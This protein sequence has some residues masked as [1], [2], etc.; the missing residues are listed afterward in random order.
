MIPNCSHVRRY[1]VQLTNAFIPHACL[2]EMCFVRRRAQDRVLFN[3]F[4]EMIFFFFFVIWPFGTGK[5]IS[6]ITVNV[7][8]G[9]RI[10]RIFFIYFFF[11]ATFVNDF[12][13]KFT[14]NLVLRSRTKRTIAVDRITV[15]CLPA[16]I[17]QRY[18]RS[19]DVITW[20]ALA[21]EIFYTC[22]YGIL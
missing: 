3:L 2:I 10:M 6:S 13:G 15:L 18:R 1:I 11:F 7:R 5:K 12:L 22:R 21:P 16:K 17:I 8:L 20:M 9:I 14:L 19:I 4:Y